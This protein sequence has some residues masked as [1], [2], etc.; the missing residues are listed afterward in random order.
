[1]NVGCFEWTIALI[2]AKQTPLFEFKPGNCISLYNKT[3]SST[4][5][6]SWEIDAA[7]IASG[8]KIVTESRSATGSFFGLSQQQFAASDPREFKFWYTLL[9]LIHSLHQILPAHFICASCHA[10][11]E[12]PILCVTALAGCTR[13]LQRYPPWVYFL[14]VRPSCSPCRAMLFPVPTSLCKTKTSSC[15]RPA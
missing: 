2:D 12:F 5:L 8:R 11:C 13:R 9:A 4:S 1:M 10:Q 6:H 14:T 15:R 7:D 3:I